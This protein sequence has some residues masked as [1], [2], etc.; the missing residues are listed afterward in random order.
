MN[1]ASRA[2]RRLPQALAAAA[3]LTLLLLLIGSCFLRT[4]FGPVSVDQLLFHLQHGGLEQ[5]DARML[6]RLW[7]WGA[8]TL[9]LAGLAWL[10][11]PRLPGW[12]RRTSWLLLSAGAAVSVGA[13]VQDSCE[14][15]DA[16]PDFLA[17]HYA[18][19]AQ[20]RLVKSEGTAPD[21][22][23]VFVESLDE[24]YAWP[25]DAE[26]PLI[27]KLADW[28]RGRQGGELQNLNS[29]SFTLAGMFGV[30]CGLPLQPVGLMSR[31][32]FE[33]S[34][35]FFA[36]GR[37]LTDLMAEQGWQVSFFGGASLR[38]AGKGKFLAA[39][40][41]T[42]RFGRDEWR[43][44]GLAMPAEGWGL[45][46]S[47]LTEQVWLDMQQPRPDARPRMDIVL[48]V[49]THGP[50]GMEDPG[51]APPLAKAPEPE[52]LM[53]LSLRCTDRAVAQLVQ[54]FLARADG[55]PKLVW[56]MGDH[57]AP[58][59]LLGAELAAWPDE[60]PLLFHAM[61]RQDA[62]GRE[63]GSL[64]QSSRVFSHFD[65]MPTLA[66]AAGLR[67]TPQTHRLG[68]GV[69]LLAQQAPRTLLERSGREVL[70]ARLSCPSPLF[71][72]L[73]RTAG[74]RG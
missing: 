8:G 2:P 37:C 33:H 40:G 3:L 16:E 41:V 67:W 72:R 70:D 13:T 50:A 5:A 64:L 20:Q 42:R 10:L 61:A 73:W 66:E 7:R 56:V 22:L 19:P 12:L 25:I 36:G 34:Q 74:A 32:A 29:V 30:L 55:R 27:P 59:Q 69:S 18:D 1:P 21:V 46:D 52:A 58:V 45:L 23:L 65:V 51:C 44:R 14:A 39:H 57:V 53:R 60:V 35:R 4:Y 49:N 38:F 71:Q 31:N 28:A 24:A 48:T 26:R 54:R 15:D 43:A 63:Q 17:Q 9:L 6:E 62:Q 68:L 47:A 11:L